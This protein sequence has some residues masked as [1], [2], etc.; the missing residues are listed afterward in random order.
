MDT[1]TNALEAPTPESPAVHLA[2]FEA[3]MA[4]IDKEIAWHYGQIALLKVKRNAIAPICKLPNEL[5]TRILIIYAVESRALFNLKW[6]NIMYVCRHWYA[7]ALAAQPLWGFIDLK[8]SGGFDRFYTQLTRSGA[9]PLVVRMNFHDSSYEAN[10]ILDNSKRICELDIGG[11]AKHVYELIARLQ[12][13]DFPILS[14]LSLDSSYKRYEL[15][16]G[17]VQAL[18]EALFDGR[19]PKLHGP[20]PKNIDFPWASL[21]GLTTL[22]LAQCGD[23]SAPLPP[24]FNG[25]LEMLGSCP[26]L[27]TLK[28]EVVIPEPPSDQ[29]FAAVELP[30]LAWLDLHDNIYSCERLL[31]Y[32][33]LPPTTSIQIL[34]DVVRTG[35]DIRNLLVPIRKHL[36]APGARRLLLFKINRFG[37]SYCTMQVFGD[38]APR[39][40]LS[41]DSETES[42]RCPISLN[43]HPGTEGALRQIL[44][45]VLKAVPSES[46]THLDARAAT[47]VSAVTWRAVITLLPAV[48]MIY[49]GVNRG[50]VNC[51][52]ALRELETLNGQ[53][54]TTVPRVRIRRLHILALRTDKD[55]N[56]VEMLLDALEE[57]LQIC[58]DTSEHPLDCL[59]LED[60]HHVF[61]GQ[62]N[63]LEQLFPLVKGDI[64]WNDA[65]F[66]PVK[67][68]E[69]LAKRE[70][71]RRALSIKYGF[72]I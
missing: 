45:K 47:S 27:R 55:D 40:Y 26:Q 46:I 57:Y 52:H 70:A 14:S 71:K 32:L 4:T 25:L 65:I 39:E 50:A 44:T 13:H 38:T 42:M 64:L 21:S 19:F 30:S 20:G 11:E 54:R 28:L 33:H 62:D 8:W 15:P 2:P 43:C 66:D 7:L 69:K 68:K 10:I 67:R 36:R 29:F 63:R 60:R 41:S 59:Q 31:N 12:K 16:K 23:S 56:T 6:T 61:A 18:P 37:L 17:F 34:P 58:C 72:E 53:R 5:M 22:A 3:E 48:E 49:L 24:T 1:E 9:A 35:A 51:V